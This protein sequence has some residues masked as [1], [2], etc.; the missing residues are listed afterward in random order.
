MAVLI[1]D[2]KELQLVSKQT[3]L[4]HKLILNLIIDIIYKINVNYNTIINTY[5]DHH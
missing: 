3:N 2:V 4:F 5:D 1:I